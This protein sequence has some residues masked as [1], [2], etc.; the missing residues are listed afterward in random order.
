MEHESFEKP[1]HIL[2]D[3]VIVGRHTVRSDKM[4]PESKRYQGLAEG[5][6]VE[7]VREA[8][9]EVFDMIESSDKDAL[10]VFIGASEEPRVQVTVEVMGDLLEEKYKGNH[11]EAV[12][13][14][15]QI[16]KMRT[17][18]DGN[19]EKFKVIQNLSNLI[20]QNRDKQ[21]ILDYPLFVKELSLR[22]HIR[23]SE[24]AVHTGFAQH[25]MDRAKEV[26][27][28]STRYGAD[29]KVDKLASYQAETTDGAKVFMSMQKKEEV[30]PYGGA[31]PQYIAEQHVRAIGR[32]TSFIKR[33]LQEKD[34]GRQL[35]IGM[36]GHGW[37]LDAFFSYLANEGKANTEG[38]IKATGDGEAVRMPEMA[39]IKIGRRG[40][41]STFSFRGKSFEIPNN[42]L[43][44]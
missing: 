11:Q 23:Q 34:R 27:G 22:P 42:A 5:V 38:Y 28:D 12:V 39:K 21:V 6:A 29:G 4:P 14:R 7:A 1:G 8:M 10:I 32:L 15:S 31:T 25:I 37:N 41:S 20:A 43:G 2:P 33:Q 40:E 30:A 19:P 17:E 16:E 13:T 24:T 26:H 9:P 36:I 44:I 18:K 3:G 35:I